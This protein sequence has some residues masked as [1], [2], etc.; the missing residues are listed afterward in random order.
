[1]PEGET[2]IV[3]GHQQAAVA[4]VGAHKL[5][6]GTAVGTVA[7]DVHDGHA[8]VVQLAMLGHHQA[9]VR[10]ARNPSTHQAQALVLPVAAC[11]PQAPLD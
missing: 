4:Y 7:V 5:Q 10:C 3:Q 8:L 6:V 9:S 1:M 11:G 2:A